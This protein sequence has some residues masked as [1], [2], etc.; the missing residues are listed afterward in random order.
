ME[1]ASNGNVQN[2]PSGGSCSSL[3]LY[4][5]TDAGSVYT[6]SNLLNGGYNSQVGVAKSCKVYPDDNVNI[7][8]FAASSL[9]VFQ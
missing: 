9:I 1:A 8:A 2:Y 4:D 6:Y 5:H 7:E 3:N